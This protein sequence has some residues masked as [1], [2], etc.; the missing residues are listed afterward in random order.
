MHVSNPDIMHFVEAPSYKPPSFEPTVMN[1]PG[2]AVDG[3]PEAPAARVRGKV[4]KKSAEVFQGESKRRV[5]A[6]KDNVSLVLSDKE[7][8]AIEALELD[9][10]PPD[11]F[12]APS[13]SDEE[14]RKIKR[15]ENPVINAVSYDSINSVKDPRIIGGFDEEGMFQFFPHIKRYIDQ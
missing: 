6:K 3:S 7:E 14:Y 9:N 5:S 1:I 10:Q 15:G 12:E 11:D 4:Q 2:K 8:P 13:K